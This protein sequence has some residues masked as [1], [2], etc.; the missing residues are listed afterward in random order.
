MPKIL[1]NIN[2]ICMENDY[3]K[4]THK[5]YVDNILIKNNFYRDYF[6]SGGWGPCYNNFYEVWKK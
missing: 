3:H 1:N 4:A 5:Y 2:L 6:E